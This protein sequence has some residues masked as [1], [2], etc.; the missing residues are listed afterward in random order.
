MVGLPLEANATDIIDEPWYL[1]A[2]NYVIRPVIVILAWMLMVTVVLG[3]LVVVTAIWR[4]KQLHSATNFLV[5]SLAVA[6][7]FVGSLV[8]PFSILT[9]LMSEEWP[10]G[11]YWCD[12]WHSF[13][14]LCSTASI[15]NLVTI[16]YD[17]YLAITNPI[18]YPTQMTHKKVGIIIVFLWTLAML[19]S[20]PAIFWW[21]YTAPAHMIDVPNKCYFT[22]DRTYLIVSSMVSFYVPFVIM[23]YAYC[24]IYK[25]AI[26]QTRFLNFGSKTIKINSS[27]KKFYLFRGSKK[28]SKVQLTDKSVSDGKPQ[29][30]IVLRAHRGGGSG[31]NQS[32]QSNCH[33]MSSSVANRI[34]LSK[35]PASLRP[36]MTMN[37]D[38]SNDSSSQSHHP[39]QASFK[40]PNAKVKLNSSLISERDIS[41]A[42][43]YSARSDTSAIM[44]PQIQKRTYSE[45]QAMK[46]NVDT[47]KLKTKVSV[48]E[49]DLDSNFGDESELCIAGT[50]ETRF[51]SLR[52]DNMIQSIVD[53]KT[54]EYIDQTPNK[55]DQVTT[56]SRNLK[57]NLRI[58]HIECSENKLEDKLIKSEKAPLTMR[59]EISN[60]ISTNISLVKKTSDNPTRHK[61][62]SRKLTKLAKE[63]KAAKTLGIV[64]G[65][66]VLCWLPFFVANIIRGLCA[67][68]IYKPDVVMLV[69]TW[70]G[71]FN[72][73]MNPFIYAC[74]SREFR[75]AFRKV[76]KSWSKFICWPCYKFCLELKITNNQNSRS[77]SNNT[78]GVRNKESFHMSS[79]NNTSISS[80]NIVTNSIV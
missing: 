17:R 50:P 70:L 63:R 61:N 18:K 12:I 35:A 5:A 67:D 53:L 32:L 46:I 27:Q 28:Q 2:S 22:G 74:W 13:D 62:V 72:S 68:C 43:T 4:E 57:S 79:K 66:F 58:D 39:N 78:S 38:A 71:W 54:L 16:S 42:R 6:D 80:R 48:C 3:N 51:N 65:V 1:V 75:R 76:L 56:S 7:C 44:K 25:E 41:K 19:I 14:V 11:P 8:M 36:L 20:F 47:T 40:V 55:E 23:L 45:S 26:R 33:S 21:H 60:S 52:P 37:S 34:S 73:A 69:V 30:Q 24:R 9:E 10:F 64:V 31:T 59:Q 77:N 29:E 49:A 15:F